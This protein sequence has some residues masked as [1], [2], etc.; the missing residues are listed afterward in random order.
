MSNKDNIVDTINS[1]G[2]VGIKKIDLKKKYTV[3]NFDSILDELIQEEKVCIS[4]KGSFIYCWN[5]EF[6]LEYL[7]NSDLK[8]KYLYQSITNIQNKINNY[9]DSIFKYIENID[10]ELVE[11][12][13]SFNNMENKINDMK[14]Q[15]QDIG[16]IESNITLDNFKESFDKILIEKSSSIGWI[17]LS[18]IKNELCQICDISNNDFYNYV[19]NVTELYPETYEL[20][21]GGYEGVIL[22]GIVHGFVRCI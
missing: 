15:S 1:F 14:I 8:F 4:K 20:S 2:S 21:S 17:E 6:F 11:I 10:C 3:E 16:I 22:R 13:S 18:S 19:S 9:S 12:K 5:K 7:L